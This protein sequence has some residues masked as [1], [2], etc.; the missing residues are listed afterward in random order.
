MLFFF[1]NFLASVFC[2]AAQ[3]LQRKFIFSTLRRPR[4]IFSTKWIFLLELVAIIHLD[5]LLEERSLVQNR[6]FFFV[7][8]A[9]LEE[10]ATFKERLYTLKCLA[11]CT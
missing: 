1:I 7:K 4:Q 2:E 9:I 5:R 10:I 8:I 11:T 3:T 6:P